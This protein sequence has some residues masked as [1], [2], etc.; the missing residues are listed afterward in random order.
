MQMSMGAKAKGGGVDCVVL[1][2]RLQFSLALLRDRALEGQCEDIICSMLNDIPL[3]GAF[4]AALKE[5]LARL[6]HDDPRVVKSKLRLASYALQK[7]GHNTKVISEL[8]YFVKQ[9]EN[10]V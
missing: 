4:P 9:V 3:A 8:P 7:H 6:E 1:R 10:F 5:I 2:K